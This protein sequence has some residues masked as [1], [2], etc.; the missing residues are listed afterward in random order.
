MAILNYILTKLNL[1]RRRGSF[2]IPQQI[3]FIGVCSISTH[4][5]EYMYMYD[6]T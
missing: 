6:S 2:T 5:W 3:L 4:V 1:S